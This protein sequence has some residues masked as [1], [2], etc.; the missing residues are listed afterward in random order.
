[1]PKEQSIL[2]YFQLAVHL[3]ILTGTAVYTKTAD[4]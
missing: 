2:L 4:R 3:N 1:M